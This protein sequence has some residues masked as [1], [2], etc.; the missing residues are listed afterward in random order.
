MYYYKQIDLGTITTCRLKEKTSF[1]YFTMLTV[2]IQGLEGIGHTTV[3]SEK[4]RSYS[5]GR[6][7]HKFT[8]SNH[9]NIKGSNEVIFSHLD[10]IV[11][12]F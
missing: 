1:E 12:L 10:N 2:C 8:Y 6:S 11:I 9:K 5:S 3:C 7:R 4:S